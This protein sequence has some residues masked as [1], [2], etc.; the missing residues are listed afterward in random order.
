ME[1]SRIRGGS[2]PYAATGKKPVLRSILHTGAEFTLVPW[3]NWSSAQRILELYLNA[4]Q[5]IDNG[6]ASVWHG[7][8]GGA[9]A[10]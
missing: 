5:S 4:V 9:V 1:G 7:L 8:A 6:I 3:P 2:A 10:A